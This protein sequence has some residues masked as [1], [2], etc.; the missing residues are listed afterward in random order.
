MTIYEETFNIQLQKLPT[1]QFERDVQTLLTPLIRSENGNYFDNCGTGGD[2]IGTFNISTTAA[3][4]LAA[5]GV[6]IAKNGNS[7]ISSQ[8]GSSDVL[9]ALGISTVTT[10]EEAHQQIERFGLTFLHAPHMQPLMRRVKK[11][12]EHYKRPT[13]FNDIGPLTNPFPLQSQYVGVTK[14]ALLPHYAKVLQTLGRRRFLVL[15]NETGMDEAGLVGRNDYIFYDGLQI[16]KGFFYASDYGFKSA[17]LTPLLGRS[18]EE[19]CNI[20]IRLLRGEEKGARRDIVVLNSALGFL[21]YGTVAT[22]EE[23]IDR[24]QSIITSGHA[25]ALLLQ[26]KEASSC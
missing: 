15:T 24:A 14:R 4:I 17:P 1:L 11:A 9:R 20:L 19:N 3:F 6:P 25:Y 18:P 2:G 16:E 21:T 23:G 22:L 7:A 12:R 5:G 26:L 10:L 13:V 8:S